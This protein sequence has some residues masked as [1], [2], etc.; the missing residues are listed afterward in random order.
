MIFDDDYYRDT[1]PVARLPIPPQNT[2]PETGEL[3]REVP[4]SPESA[5][6]DD[7]PALIPAVRL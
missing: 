4:A 1:R 5:D 7:F 6:I 2:E 3:A